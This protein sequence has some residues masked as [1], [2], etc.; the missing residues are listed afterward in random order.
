MQVTGAQRSVGDLHRSRL[1]LLRRPVLRRDRQRLLHCSF[2]LPIHRQL[3]ALRLIA[4]Q[5]RAAIRSLHP[6]DAIEIGLIRCKD[7][8]DLRVLQIQPGNVAGVVIVAEQSIRAQVQIMCKRRIGRELRRRP[9]IGGH[10][11]HPLSI[12]HVIRVGEETVRN[13]HHRLAQSGRKVERRR[14]DHRPRAVER[15]LLLRMRRGVFLNHST[16]G[17]ERIK[18]VA[19][20]QRFFGDER[21]VVAGLGHIPPAPIDREQAVHVSVLRHVVYRPSA[22][23]ALVQINLIHQVA[24][25]GELGDHLLLDGR[26]SG[27][28]VR[29]RNHLPPRDAIGFIVDRTAAHAALRRVQTGLGRESR[30]ARP[31]WSEH[32]ILVRIRGTNL[33]GGRYRQREREQETD[34]LKPQHGVT[35]LE[36]RLL[37]HL[38]TSPHKGYP[39]LNVAA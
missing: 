18:L 28:R 30:R 24:G 1:S 12:S 5:D 17:P 33:A 26:Q 36:R 14:P 39:Q 8:I 13:A 38:K 21:G 35:S 4:D 25:V 9:Q 15:G 7:Q 31:G 32:R 19:R 11:L 34:R 27:P 16:G 20:N 6:E 29:H 2:V 22:Q 37:S 3:A 23:V 10:R